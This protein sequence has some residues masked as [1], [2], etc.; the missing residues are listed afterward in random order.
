MLLISAQLRPSIISRKES[1]L[2]GVSLLTASNNLRFITGWRRNCWNWGI[3]WSSWC[4]SDIFHYRKLNIDLFGFWKDRKKQKSVRY[5]KF[6]L[7]FCPLH[8]NF[9]VV[10]R[11]PWCHKTGA[12]HYWVTTAPGQQQL[13]HHCRGQWG[14]VLF[15]KTRFSHLPTARI[16]E[17]A[18][19]T[20]DPR[21]SV[22][23][24]E[25]R[26]VERQL[27]VKECKSPLN[28]TVAKVQLVSDKPP[29]YCPGMSVSK[30]SYKSWPAQHS[31][32][33]ISCP[34]V[35]RIY[36]TQCHWR[37]YYSFITFDTN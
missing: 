22:L 29:S 34:I 3:L 19:N 30:L 11:E 13:Q 36:C 25:P 6:P 9:I 31:K 20:L 21:A 24:N 26:R 16:L 2:R 1:G 33:G 28:L 23:I 5:N 35:P 15:Y 17:L 12:D 32:L 10:G 14:R 8:L 7:C 37:W 4:M 18:W 27:D